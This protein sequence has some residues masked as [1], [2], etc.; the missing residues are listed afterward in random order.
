MQLSLALVLC[1]AEQHQLECTNWNCNAAVLYQPLDIGE[2][3]EYKTLPGGQDA[4][5]VTGLNGST[6]GLPYV[7]QPAGMVVAPHFNQ[8]EV[9]S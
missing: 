9:I 3:V 2:P 1:A 6:L 5:S 7:A 4:F 8:P